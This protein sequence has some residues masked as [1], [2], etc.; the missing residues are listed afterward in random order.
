MAFHLGTRL[1][2]TRWLYDL[3]NLILSAVKVVKAA[4]LSFVGS[5][6]LLARRHGRKPFWIAS[7]ITHGAGAF[8]F[9]C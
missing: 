3:W 8:M 1:S 9:R 5:I 4:E 7:G 6:P 2:W